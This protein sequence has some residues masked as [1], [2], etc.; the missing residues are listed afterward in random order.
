MAAINAGPVRRPVGT[1]RPTS[2]T[3]VTAAKAAWPEGND[4]EVALTRAPG[5]GMV[6]DRLDG[7]GFVAHRRH[8]ADHQ[9]GD[10]SPA[11]LAPEDQSGDGDD[12]PAEREPSER[13]E[14]VLR[15]VRQSAAADRDRPVSPA[16]VHAER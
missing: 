16:E 8:L 4:E 6:D 7:V 14:D 10:R 2:R 13:A 15:D 11:P 12:Q 5:G 9:D 1:R 3:A